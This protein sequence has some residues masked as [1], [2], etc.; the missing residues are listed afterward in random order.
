LFPHHLY[1]LAVSCVFIDQLLCLFFSFRSWSSSRCTTVPSVCLAGGFINF[2]VRYFPVFRVFQFCSIKPFQYRFSP[3]TSWPGLVT[4]F[5][6]GGLTLKFY[7]SHFGV[8]ELILIPP[9]YAFFSCHFFF[10][11]LVRQQTLIFCLFLDVV[12]GCA[13]MVT[14]SLMS[15]IY[16]TVGLSIFLILGSLHRQCTD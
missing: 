3:S 7:A 1:R 11:L 13:L 8:Y 12:C 10:R 2:Y 14:G 6:C 9:L 5:F 4:A 16:S 15:V